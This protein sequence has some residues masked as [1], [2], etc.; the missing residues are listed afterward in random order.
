[1]IASFEGMRRSPFFFSHLLRFGL[2]A[3]VCLPLSGVVTGC[4][5]MGGSSGSSP[6][7][8]VSGAAAVSSEET[9][10]TG[11][12]N[13]QESTDPNADTGASTQASLPISET[14]YE[15]PSPTY[16]QLGTTVI[17]EADKNG[18]V[19]IQGE[20]FDP[21]YFVKV[22][23]VSAVERD[24][25]Q[26]NASFLRLFWR[27]VT[28]PLKRAADD[29]F[30][31]LHGVLAGEAFAGDEAFPESCFDAY[32]ACLKAN[33]EGFLPAVP[34]LQV[35][36]GDRF[37]VDYL[38]P[39]TGEELATASEKVF[40]SFTYL[41]AAPA[42]SQSVTLTPEGNLLQID[43]QGQV[44]SAVYDREARHLVVNSGAY[45]D[46][47]RFATY[48]GHEGAIL[49]G[50]FYGDKIGS[51]AIWDSERISLVD[52]QNIGRDGILPVLST[53]FAVCHGD[54]APTNVR[55][56]MNDMF[57][58]TEYR[59]APRGVGSVFK[60]GQ[61]EDPLS[62]PF[63]D[64]A[65]NVDEVGA[66]IFFKRAFVFDVDW[67]VDSDRGDDPAM[68]ALA[69]FEDE[70][71]VTYLGASSRGVVAH[72]VP[73][74]M[75]LS[76][77]H[78]DVRDL[79]I[80]VPQP[81][82]DALDGYAMAIVDKRISVIRFDLLNIVDEVSIEQ[83]EMKDIK[84]GDKPLQIIHNAAGQRLYIL[85]QGNL[86]TTYDRIT[87]LDLSDVGHPAYARDLPV[88]IDPQGD[89]VIDF[90]DV[91]DGRKITFN[92]TAM[93][94]VEVDGEGILFV[95][96]RTYQGSLPLFV[97]KVGRPPT[98]EFEDK[99]QS[100]VASPELPGVVL[101]KPEKVIPGAVVG[102]PSLGSDVVAPDTKILPNGG[103]K[104]SE[105]LESRPRVQ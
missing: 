65:L 1:M 95:N 23:N 27:T 88:D 102:P 64:A 41:A 17:S 2:L 46:G 73:M 32:T 10:D 98:K 70:S 3:A 40:P 6:S 79:S 78:V 74:I 92:A 66:P 29:V 72:P 83:T 86:F 28:V 100:S 47:Y 37:S 90:A 19:A 50:I 39:D 31:V 58:V 61:D 4:F 36:P 30:D 52:S 5:E 89:G 9:V 38:D 14:E 49:K 26:L 60:F 68:M 22:T 34:L 104:P 53:S 43:S 84:I 63:V 35:I 56:Q 57:F 97:G 24:E 99:E 42:S 75:K 20:G 21:N 15:A 71:G 69:V 7:Q 81:I 51:L 25:A 87:V 62:I 54:C 93:T 101:E 16:L 44:V 96:S 18:V 45:D 12:S 13:F 82:D 85:E 67:F 77:R 55:S 8:S 103:T 11:V 80:F 33:P 91:L 76:D 105:P 59:D 94:F 48:Q